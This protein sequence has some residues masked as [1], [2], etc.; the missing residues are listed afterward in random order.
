MSPFGW[1]GINW[2]GA[3]TASPPGSTFGSA[4]RR[5]FAV[6]NR[7]LLPIPAIVSKLG[8][9]SGGIPGAAGLP[10]KA[11][12]VARNLGTTDDSAGFSELV[13]ET[14]L[15][16]GLLGAVS[17]GMVANGVGTVTPIQALMS[18]PEGIPTLGVGGTMASAAATWAGN[19]ILVGAA[20]EIGI[21]MGSVIGA[22]YD[23][24]G[25]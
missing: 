21:G 3:V 15:L 11:I 20:F 9:L 12:D 18:L 14:Q 7:V 16:V 4:F 8:R 2:A 19:A 1:G 10:L 23:T 24:W 17:S 25:P 6:T 22:A 13:S 5:R